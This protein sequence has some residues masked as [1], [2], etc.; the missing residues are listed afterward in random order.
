MSAS[1]PDPHGQPTAPDRLARSL[2]LSPDDIREIVALRDRDEVP[3]QYI[4]EVITREAE[5]IEERIGQLV[6][7]R[8][9]LL[10]LHQLAA[11]LPDNPPGETRVCHILE[12][13][14]VDASN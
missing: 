5:A 14:K 12:Q 13:A 10:R 11:E 2:G 6:T 8:A 1:P 3:C 4:R 9:E 7:L